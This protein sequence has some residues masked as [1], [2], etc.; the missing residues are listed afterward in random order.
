MNQIFI[1]E[2]SATLED[3][4]LGR[5]ASQTLTEYAYQLRLVYETQLSK[6]YMELWVR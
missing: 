5:E 4:K 1:D 6:A 3:Y 2:A